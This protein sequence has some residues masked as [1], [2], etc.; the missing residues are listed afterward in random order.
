MLKMWKIC[1]VLLPLLAIGC[2]KPQ[3]STVADKNSGSVSGQSPAATAEDSKAK[4][5]EAVKT[6]L[7]KVDSVGKWVRDTQ[8][9]F[10]DAMALGDPSESDDK[11]KA[12]ALKA[13]DESLK[14]YENILKQIQSLNPVPKDCEH[15]Q[16]DVLSWGT[17]MRDGFAEIKKRVSNNHTSE[18]A[19]DSQGI[20]SLSESMKL[21]IIDIKGKYG[22]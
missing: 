9:K 7:A 12:Y 13:I 3:D 4:E 17:K 10:D 2:G 5:K 14:S 18:G 16:A 19:S 1:I 6:Y 22:L 11:R 21:Q 8:Y 15:L 20:K